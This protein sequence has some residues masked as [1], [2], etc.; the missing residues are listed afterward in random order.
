MD[1]RTITLYDQITE[2]R[3]R[4]EW[5]YK[6]QFSQ[7][8]KYHTKNNWLNIGAIIAS[9][10]ASLFSASNGIASVADIPQAWISF[11]AA[12]ISGAGAILL[13]CNQNLSY[14]SKI[15]QNVEMGAKIW[16]IYVDFESLLTDMNTGICTY[17]E[18][19]ARR[20][21]I[22]D[23]WTKL[24]EVAPLTF[25]EAVKAADDN[26]NKRGDN[27]FKQ[28]VLDKSLPAFLRIKREQD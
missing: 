9:G 16:R 14:I 22:L 3:Y 12:A 23:R 18:A 15:P 10:L 25:A 2:L 7:A 4:A 17:E 20:E 5:T 6:I 28:E 8:E 26:L 21:G 11:T 1:A 24:S 27:T 19:L 13:A